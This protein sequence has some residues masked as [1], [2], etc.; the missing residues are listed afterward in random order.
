M[1]WVT[2]RLR[3]QMVASRVHAVDELSGA[4]LSEA[5]VMWGRIA[6]AIRKD[7]VEFNSAGGSR[8]DFSHSSKLL[9]LTP[10]QPPLDVTAFYLDVRSGTLE[11]TNRRV[12]RNG[13]QGRFSLRGGAIQVLECAGE[14]KP[15]RWPL[16]PEEFSRLMLEPIFF[17]ARS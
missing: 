14:P 8:F 12:F 4:E 2:G 11:F 10:K 6:E 1:G 7:V 17:G 3:R 13:R 5:A 16:S 15:P 9:M